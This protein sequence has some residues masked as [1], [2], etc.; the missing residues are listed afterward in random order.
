MS[1]I[2][3]MKELMPDISTLSTLWYSE[4]KTGERTGLDDGI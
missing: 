3:T 2:S 4:T 1:E